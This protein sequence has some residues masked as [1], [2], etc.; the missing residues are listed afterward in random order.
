[1]PGMMEPGR[2]FRERN[3]ITEQAALLTGGRQRRDSSV[4][5]N[6]MLWKVMN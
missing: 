3:S 5:F 2:P 1:M 4:E 6:A